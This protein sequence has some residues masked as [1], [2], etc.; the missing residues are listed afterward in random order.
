MD[1]CFISAIIVAG[2]IGT[3][4]GGNLPKQFLEIDGLQV[5]EH[6]VR[7]FVQSKAVDQIV[8]VCH[9]DYIS[10][11]HKLFEH[12][13][14]DI[15]IVPGSDT[16]QKSVFC[17]LEAC[18]EADYVLIHDA[19]R[20]CVETQDICKLAHHLTQKKACALG[21]RVFDTVKKTGNDGKITDTVDRNNL[22]LVQT[23]QA[24]E[25][26]LIYDSHQK[27]LSCGFEATDD[28]ALAEH[29]GYDVYIVEGSYKNIKITTPADLVLAAEYLKG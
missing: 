29:A 22:W 26:T 2:G 4:M 8:I 27:A 19:V 3:R 23:P 11:T 16:R 7:R 9:K 14:F 20:C 24:F 25:R 28:C 17:G 15:N 1:K 5:I 21:V 12:I 13:D 6:T 10:H 18:P